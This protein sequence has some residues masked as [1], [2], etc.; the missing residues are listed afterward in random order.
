MCHC[1][2]V[3][4]AVPDVTLDV[5][6]LWFVGCCSNGEMPN[7][8]PVSPYPTANFCDQIHFV[9]FLER[10]HVNMSKMYFMKDAR[11]KIQ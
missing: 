3:S 6:P 8:R 9:Q 2:R 10:K 4:C 1:E 7:Y 11:C 5:V